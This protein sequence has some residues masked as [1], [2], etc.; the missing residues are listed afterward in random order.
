MHL[1]RAVDCAESD[2][3]GHDIVEVWAEQGKEHEDDAHKGSQIVS[4]LVGIFGDV[5]HFLQQRVNASLG[6]GLLPIDPAGC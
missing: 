1:V 4:Q 5:R 2:D 6:L 3:D